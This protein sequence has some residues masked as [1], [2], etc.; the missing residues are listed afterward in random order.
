M[1]LKV[2]VTPYDDSYW[3]YFENQTITIREELVEF[4]QKTGN[5]TNLVYNPPSKR[6]FPIRVAIIGDIMLEFNTQAYLLNNNG[7]TV[8]SFS[9]Y[10]YVYEQ[11]ESP[12][13]G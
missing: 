8:E 1:I 4:N 5:N 2:Q 3:Q 11:P 7:S 12:Q 10:S 6:P 9:L 13:Q